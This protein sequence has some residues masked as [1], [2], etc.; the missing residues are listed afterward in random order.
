MEVHDG[1]SR[2]KQANVDITVNWGKEDR[3]VIYG[4]ETRQDRTNIQDNTQQ[5]AEAKHRLAIWT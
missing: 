3:Q 4:P 5:R 1:G 2:Q